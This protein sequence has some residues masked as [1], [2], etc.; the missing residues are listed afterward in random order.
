MQ[1]RELGRTGVRV[2]A[3]C[4]GTMTF[5]EQNNEKDAHAQRDVP[6]DADINF[7][8]TAEVYP[9]P[10]RENTQGRTESWIG[11]WLRKSRRR[12]Q[13]VHASRAYTEFVRVIDTNVV[14]GVGTT[15]FGQ[16]KVLNGGRLAEICDDNSFRTVSAIAGQVGGLLTPCHNEQNSTCAAYETLDH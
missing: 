15:G 2:S 5:G 16:H 9:V 8:N 3:L 1:F 11:S 14:N 13:I 10:P 7:I 6:L 4:L 12:D